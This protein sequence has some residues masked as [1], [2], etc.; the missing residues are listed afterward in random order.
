MSPRQRFFAFLA[1]A[2]TSTG[3]GSRTG[4][5]SDAAGNLEP[6][7]AG[8]LDADVCAMIPLNDGG[9]F[10]GGSV[11]CQAL[12]AYEISVIEDFETGAAAGWQIDNDRTAVQIPAPDTDPPHAELIPGGRCLDTQGMQSQYAL[13]IVSGTLASYGGVFSRRFPRRLVNA[14]PCPVHACEDRPPG[15]PPMGPCGN[16]FSLPDQPSA[17]TACLTGADESVWEGIVLWARKGT[18]SASNIRVQLGDVHTDESNQA[19]DCALPGTHADPSQV[20][21]PFSLVQPVDATFRPYLFPFRLMRQSGQGKPSPLGLDTSQLFSIAITYGR[22]AWDLWI[23]DIGF[24]RRK[25]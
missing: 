7:A 24:Y 14:T 13:H 3:C 8:N 5:Q 18:S 6:D 23:D 2:A 11:D 20:C 17:T 15:P 10:N 12:S 1:W 9:D 25:P 19:C 22:G 21:D 4:Q 16:G